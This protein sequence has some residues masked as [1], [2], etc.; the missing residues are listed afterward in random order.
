MSA[1]SRV[2]RF[3]ANDRLAQ[4]LPF[5]YGWVMVP[6]SM[7]TLVATAPGQTYGVSVFNPSFREALDISLSQLTG[8]YMLGTFLASLPQ[9]WIGRLMDRLGIRRLMTIIVFLFGLACFFTANVRNLVMLFL[10]FF[11]L[12]MLG[13]G[14]LMLLGTNTPAMWFRKRLGFVSGIMSLGM[15]GGTAILPPLLLFLILNFGWRT[16]YLILG[17]AVWVIMF[18]L[19]AVFFRNRPEDVGQQV[20]GKT[21]RQEPGAVSAVARA[22]NPAGSPVG[23]RNPEEPGLTLKEAQ[24]TRAYWIMLLSSALW[25]MILTAVFF[26]IIP[27]FTSQGLSEAG[28]ATT[29]TT[30][31]IVA[32]VMQFVGGVR[33]DRVPLP[34]LLS[35]SLVFLIAGIAFL[36]NANTVLLGHAYA[37][38]IGFTQG[39]FMAVGNVIWLRYYGRPHLG[40]IRGSV[41]TAIVA[42]SSAGPFIM[43][44]TYDQLGDYR[45][46]LILFIALLVPLA[47]AA[48]FATPPRREPAKAVTAA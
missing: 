32:A 17:V 7:I 26:N 4:R 20:D 15:S 25:S 16:T 19:L 33:A 12:R 39:L 36:M 47:I 24:R 5:F 42:G 35:A 2:S 22:D 11:F 40:Q 27:V 3:L 28:A 13:Q 23:D 6:I 29:F 48:F 8:A 44:F 34:W 41:V 21:G 18:P 38:M 30:L 45:W 37:V 46:S 10:A 9:P 14:A 43:G 31:S 1:T